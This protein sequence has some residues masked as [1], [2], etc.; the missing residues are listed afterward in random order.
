[1]RRLQLV[2]KLADSDK[3][4]ADNGVQFAAYRALQGTCI[5]VTDR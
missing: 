5:F 4:K 3:D 1:M 2:W